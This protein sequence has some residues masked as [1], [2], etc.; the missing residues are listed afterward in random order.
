M[1]L[2]AATLRTPFGLLTPYC[3]A[4]PSPGDWLQRWNLDPVLIAVL[5]LVGAVYFS[6]A[7][8]TQSSGWRRVA[9]HI[10][11]VTAV[12]ALISPLCPL[13]VSLFS[14][15][16]G[17]HMLLTTIAAP[18]IALG[19]PERILPAAARAHSPLTAAVAFA[20]LLWVWHAP[21][22]Y[23]ATFAS[24]I[25][26]WAMHVSLFGAALW[27]WVALLNGAADRLAGQVAAI[28]LTTGQMGLLG[29]IVTFAGAP[30]YWPH[31]F[32]TAVWGLSP[33][34]DQ[35]LGGVLMWVP[36]GGILVIGLGLAFCKTL[37]QAE[38]RALARSAY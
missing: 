29:A 7:R 19:R 27:L 38:S 21:G 11:W 9:F 30:L 33:L 10:G 25:V 23:A 18:L 26:Y 31:A 22:P 34:E 8:L 13:S 15:R 37:L 17:Q 32:T 2:S 12:L 16:V 28:L 3:G 6:R 24:D 14:A 5:A 35:Q 20:A 4:P 36:A 1:A